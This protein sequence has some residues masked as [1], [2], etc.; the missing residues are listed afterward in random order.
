MQE[1]VT[2]AF[3]ADKR[4]KHKTKKENKQKMHVLTQHDLVILY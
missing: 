4:D 1:G 2:L 3:H